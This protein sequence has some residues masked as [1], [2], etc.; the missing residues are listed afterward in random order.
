[1]TGLVNKMAHIGNQEEKKNGKK[2]K[3]GGENGGKKPARLR[4]EETGKREEGEV[5]GLGQYLRNALRSL[6]GGK[7][8]GTKKK[9]AKFTKRGVLSAQTGPQGKGTKGGQT[10]KNSKRRKTKK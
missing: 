2:E 8:A 10:Y 5:A 4:N 7:K 1:M 3:G 9:K 6:G